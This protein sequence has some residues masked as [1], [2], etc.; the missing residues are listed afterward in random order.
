MKKSK[1]K[2]MV[3]V[4]PQID[5]DSSVKLNHEKV[6]YDSSDSSVKL[7]AKHINKTSKKKF[8]IP[9]DEDSDDKSEGYKSGNSHFS[10]TS[11]KEQ[12]DEPEVPKG[13]QSKILCSV[14]L[15]RRTL[16][17][18]VQSLEDIASENDASESTSSQ[19]S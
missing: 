9:F 11:S 7:G 16:T 6:K 3:L 5:L 1:K 10:Q 19:F 2:I 8:T 13:K 14:R 17:V 15:R 18:G 4:V 12:Q